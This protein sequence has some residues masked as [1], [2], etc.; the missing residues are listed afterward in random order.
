MEKLLAHAWE[1]I[2]LIIPALIGGVVDYLNQINNGKKSRSFFGFVV[3][4]FSAMFFGWLAGSITMSL[5]YTEVH[6]ISAAGGFGGFM[7]VRLSDLIIR[8]IGVERRKKD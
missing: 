4:G 5:G 7:G 6:T 8:L 2:G 3:H 1:T